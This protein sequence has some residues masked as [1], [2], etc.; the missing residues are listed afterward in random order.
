MALGMANTYFPDNATKGLTT[1]R[2]FGEKNGIR[3]LTQE[4]W[5]ATEEDGW[6][7]SAVCNRIIKGKGAYRCP[8]ENG[9][10]FMILTD[11]RRV[12]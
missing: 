11:I 6:E 4:K 10:L 8:D 1:V 12:Q 3:K 5:D 2:D 7:M 9:A